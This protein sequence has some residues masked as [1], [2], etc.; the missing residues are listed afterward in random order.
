MFKT[1]RTRHRFRT[2]INLP[3]NRIGTTTPPSCGIVDE[4][5][6]LIIDENGNVIVHGECSEETQNVVVDESGN[7]IVDEDDNPISYE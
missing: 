6:N 2:I 7:Q 5:G 4:N 3:R 1:I